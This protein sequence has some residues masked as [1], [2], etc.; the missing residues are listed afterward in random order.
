L[1]CECISELKTLNNN[2]WAN[3]WAWAPLA[4]CGHELA[5]RAQ[6]ENV[7]GNETLKVLLRDV[8]SEV[9]A[10]HGRAAAIESLEDTRKRL[11]AFL[12]RTPE[13][14]E[15]GHHDLALGSD[16]EERIVDVLT[17]GDGTRYLSSR[18]ITEGIQRRFPSTPVEE[19]SVREAVKRMRE[20]GWPI[21]TTRRGSRIPQSKRSSLPPLFRES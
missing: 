8:Q 6:R 21:E 7:A 1:V 15:G 19:R 2:P 16:L 11:L 4:L 13:A 12:P 9:W 3:T 18:N 10:P 20:R 14:P 5:E 17:S